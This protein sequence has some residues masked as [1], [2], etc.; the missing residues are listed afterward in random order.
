SFLP[1]SGT[2]MAT[3]HVTGAFAAIRSAPNCG[4]KTVDQIA[5]ALKNTGIPIADVN[6]TKPRISVN[7][8]AKQLGCGT[9]GATE[10][11]DFNGDVKADILWRHSS[12]NVYI[13]N[14]N[15]FTIGT[16]GS[17]A[18]VTNDWSIQGVGDFDGDGKNDILWRHTS[19]LVYIWLMDGLT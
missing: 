8:A 7:L 9:G 10:T 12:G 2:S 6:H 14:M 3:P 13:W 5:T 17:P 4:T 15:G 19:G 18:N 11:H 16:T 1:L